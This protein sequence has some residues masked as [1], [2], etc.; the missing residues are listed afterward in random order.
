MRNNKLI[1]ISF[2]VGLFFSFFYSSLVQAET[3]EVEYED[4]LVI[5]SDLD[6]LTDE[7]EK[8]IFGTDINNPDSDGDGIMD[9]AEIINNADPRDN[10]SPS[11]KKVFIESLPGQIAVPWSWYLTRSSALLGFILLYLSIFLGISIKTPFLQKIISPAKSLSI[12]SRISF[13]ALFFAFIHGLSLIFDQFIGFSLINLFIPFSSLPDSAATAGVKP[14]FLNFGIIGF[15]LMLLL[16]ITSYLRKFINRR[17]W[18]AIHFFNI[19]LYVFAVAHALALGTDMKVPLVKNIFIFAN[20]A[21]FSL[22]LINIAYRIG[23]WASVS[24]KNYENLRESDSSVF[25]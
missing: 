24:K 20:I 8:Q 9:G 18:R 7:G 2:L 14:I 25:R 21:L 17:V 11:V 13:Q 22:M 23:H 16:V 3:N 15:Y 19:L 6:G 12:H 1:I 5:D 10:T 4:G